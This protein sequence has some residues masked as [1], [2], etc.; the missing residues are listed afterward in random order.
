VFVCGVQVSK[1]I[2]YVGCGGIRNNRTLISNIWEPIEPTIAAWGY[3]DHFDLFGL[4]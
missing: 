1:C 4:G 3:F 2:S